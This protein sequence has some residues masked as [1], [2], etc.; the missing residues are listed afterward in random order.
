MSAQVLVRPVTPDDVPEISAL[1]AR[2]F[3]PG[4]FARSAYR[5]REGAPLLSRFCIA[6]FVDGKL[7]AAIRFTEVTIGGREGALLLG[8]LAVE[9]GLAG[10]GYGKRLIA[11]GLEQAKAAGIDVAVLV[12]DEPYYGRF[13]FRVVP[14]GRVTLPGPVDPARIL[15]AEFKAGALARFRGMV[16]AARSPAGI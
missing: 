16:A 2:V 5:I 14:P 4:R 9:P 8:P 10:Q 11:D 1:H 3:G 13:G 6:S 7:I 12:G 15:A